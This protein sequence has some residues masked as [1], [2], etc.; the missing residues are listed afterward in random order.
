MAI[1]NYLDMNIVTNKE[2][3]NLLIVEGMAS[4]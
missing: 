2:D 3:K 1:M 4:T